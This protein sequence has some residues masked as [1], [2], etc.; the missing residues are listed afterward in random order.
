MSSATSRRRIV[1]QLS[2]WARGRRSVAHNRPVKIG[3]TIPSRAPT[4]GSRQKQYQGGEE[5]DLEQQSAHADI[6]DLQDQDW[7]PPPGH[8]GAGQGLGR[9]PRQRDRRS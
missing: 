6:G 1:S 7:P 9:P 5:P 8:A 4:A 3:K 2:C